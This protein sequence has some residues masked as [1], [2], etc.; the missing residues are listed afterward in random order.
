MLYKILLNE[1][2]LERNTKKT[3]NSIRRTL[4][5]WKLFCKCSNG[6]GN[7]MDPNQNGSQG[8]L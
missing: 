3:K 4:K 2:C 7:P 1:C 5:A 8:S 6:F